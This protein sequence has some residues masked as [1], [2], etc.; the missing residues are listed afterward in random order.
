MLE[1]IES[2]INFAIKCLEQTIMDADKL[3]DENVCLKL[4][5]EALKEVIRE[6]EK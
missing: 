5:I 3:Q 6:L 2:S 1:H 4:E